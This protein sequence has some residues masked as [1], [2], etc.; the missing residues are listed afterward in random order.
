MNP[1][2]TLLLVGACML[3]AAVGY[4][5][6]AKSGASTPVAESATDVHPHVG[7]DL[8]RTEAQDLPLERTRKPE[9]LQAAMK[10]LVRDFAASPAARHDWKLRQRAAQVLETLTADELRQFAEQFPTPVVRDSETSDYRDTLVREIMN[11]WALKDPAGASLASLRSRAGMRAGI[12]T[13]WILRDPQGAERWFHDGAT[14]AGWEH[15]ARLLKERY[16]R[17][18]GTSNVSDITALL[19]KLDPRSRDSVLSTL[20]IQIGEDPQQRAELLRLADESGSES[21]KTRVLLGVVAAVARTSPEEALQFIEEQSMTPSDKTFATETAL[22]HWSRDDPPAAMEYWAAR[23]PTEISDVIVGGFNTWH[24]RDA[25]GA[26][27]WLED[28]PSPAMRD[29]FRRG[30]AESRVDERDHADAA[31]LVVAIEDPELRLRQLKRVQQAWE[32][33]HPAQ[34]AA[35]LRSLPPEDQ[36]QL[37]PG[38]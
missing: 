32:K 38:P 17:E 25:A 12:L 6:A 7:P 14:P 11:Q 13:D 30:V 23:S 8:E 3:A 28:L 33:E 18:V 35:W 37:S 20:S 21:L 19:P 34:A 22:M 27:R 26:I 29:E 24:G 31:A 10:R 9:E 1:R 5:L 4:G 2:Q 15:E 36:Q 16:V